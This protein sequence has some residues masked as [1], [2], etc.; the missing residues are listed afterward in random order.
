MLAGLSLNV[1]E[2]YEDGQGLAHLGE[3]RKA[4]HEDI[5]VIVRRS[6]AEFE[7]QRC[8]D[9]HLEA[10]IIIPGIADSRASEHH[11]RREPLTDTPHLVELPNKGSYLDR[12][13]QR[14]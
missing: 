6:V 5:Q 14:S 11:L 2:L 12:Q 3:E 8:E 7:P 9:P 1:R 4:S 10:E 13:A